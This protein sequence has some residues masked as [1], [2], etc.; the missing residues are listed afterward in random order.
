MMGIF[1][2]LFNII[3]VKPEDYFKVTLTDKWLSVENPKHAVEIVKWNDIHTIQMVN[4]LEGPWSPN[5]WLMIIGKH[6]HCRIPRDATGFNSVYEVISK[7]KGF[8]FENFNKS[9]TSSG[10]VT[11]LLWSNEMTLQH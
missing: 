4:S 7:Y 10:N 6:G 1:D 2:K 3:R 11:F 5:L 9:L 8:D